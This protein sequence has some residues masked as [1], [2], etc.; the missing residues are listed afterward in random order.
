MNIEKDREDD[1]F[2][3]ALTKLRSGGVTSDEQGRAQETQKLDSYQTPIQE[4]LGISWRRTLRKAH[5]H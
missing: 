3:W 2:S 4:A 5:F 1:T